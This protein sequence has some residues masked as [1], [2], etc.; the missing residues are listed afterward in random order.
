MDYS[1][2]KN[3]SNKDLRERIEKLESTVNEVCYTLHELIEHL[4]GM[5]SNKELRIIPPPECPPICARPVE[6]ESR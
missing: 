4:R 1:R 3:V 2:N 6:E 5:K